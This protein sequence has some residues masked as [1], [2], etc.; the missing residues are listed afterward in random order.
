[1]RSQQ[2]GQVL[3]YVND[4]I[5][6]RYQKMAPHPGVIFSC[7]GR[8]RTGAEVNQAT[9]RPESRTLSEPQRVLNP[10]A[11]TIASGDN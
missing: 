2:D 4:Q 11:A 9:V 7:N 6:R 5:R 1:M 3:S 8:I 10:I